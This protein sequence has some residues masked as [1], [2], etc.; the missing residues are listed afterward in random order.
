MNGSTY[1]ITIIS[2]YD[3]S[4]YVTEKVVYR[5]DLTKLFYGMTLFGALIDGRAAFNPDTGIR[6]IIVHSCFR[7]RGSRYLYGAL[8]HLHWETTCQELSTQFFAR[9][10]SDAGL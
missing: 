9:K 4:V 8:P 10:V 5:R 3:L 6:G 7:C 1:R 2:P